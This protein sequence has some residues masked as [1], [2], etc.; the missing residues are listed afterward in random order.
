MVREVEREDETAMEE[1]VEGVNS[2]YVLLF[3][4]INENQIEME[5]WGCE[6][7]EN[8]GIT[9][10]DCRY[11]PNRPANVY[12]WTKT[13]S[14]CCFRFRHRQNESENSIDATAYGE[15][16]KKRNCETWRARSEC[17]I[18][19]DADEHGHRTPNDENSQRKRLKWFFFI[20]FSIRFPRMK[21][22]VS[23]VDVCP[24]QS[25]AVLLFP[26]PCRRTKNRLRFEYVPKPH[27]RCMENCYVLMA[28]ICDA[29]H[30]IQRVVVSLLRSPVSSAFC[31]FHRP[32]SCRCR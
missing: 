29:F 1:T 11:R 4:K 21:S 26:F 20:D 27:C 6:W 12:G 5:G 30:L 16:T 28:E 14:G 32:H 2:L 18:R 31:R 23:S 15:R 7:N 9:G 17:R 24:M 25:I 22:T 3:G 8:N 13:P 10:C 19:H